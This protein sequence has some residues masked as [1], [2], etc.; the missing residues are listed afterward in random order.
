MHD[1]KRAF[2]LI[3]DEEE[4]HRLMEEVIR[5]KTAQSHWYKRAAEPDNHLRPGATAVISSWIPPK[6]QSWMKKNSENKQKLRLATRSAEGTADHDLSEKLDRGEDFE[7]TTVNIDFAKKWEKLKY[8]HHVE[9]HEIEKFVLSDGFGIAGAIDR[10]C[11]L[12]DN[13]GVRKKYIVDLKT[14]FV[15]EKAAWQMAAYKICL[16][17]MGGYDDLGLCVFQIQRGREPKAIFYQKP[18]VHMASFVGALHMWKETFYAKPVFFE[19]EQGL[20]LKDLDWKWRDINFLDL[21]AKEFC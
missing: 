10:I 17:E 21:W 6:L 20:S 14:G 15:S 18:R 3:A 5:H 9:I 12:T 1:L 11:T 13:K 19:G 16:E 4:Q 7:K 2:A 8:D